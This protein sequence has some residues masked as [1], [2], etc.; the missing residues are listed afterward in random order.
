M[1]SS[2]R[3]Y[4]SVILDLSIG[5][6]LDYLLPDEM[7]AVI[8]RGMRVEVPIR[9]K[10]HTGYVLEVK[11]TCSYPSVKAVSRL[12]SEEEAVP[13]ELFELALWIAK[14]YCAPLSKVMKAILPAPVRKGGRHKQQLFV[15]RKKSREEIADI[16]RDLRN[17]FPAQAAVLDAM[18]L[19]K[20]GILLTELLEQ[21]ESSRSSVDALVKKGY[22]SVDIVRIDRSPL[23]GEEYFQ[24][25]P[26]TL[27]P[28]QRE[29]LEKIC[30]S[31]DK[32][33]FDVHLLHGVT[34]SGKTEVYLQAI[35]KVLK[36]DRGVIMLVPE[37]SLTAQ[38][39]E[40]LRGRFEGHIA[41]LHHRLSVG[42][43]FDEW[44]KI[45]EGKAQIVVGARSSIF[46]PV[47]DLGL[48]IVDEEHESS[49]KQSDEA[50][51]YAG[52]VKSR[53]SCFGKCNA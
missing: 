50:P 21:S 15:M 36:Q 44:H 22:L 41:I 30:L 43:R 6:A 17:K 52:Q 3:N 42:E 10:L 25:K 28:E 35:E 53:S 49:Y 38:T 24:T 31:I 4:V 7:R 39:I 8:R 12:L 32:Q 34:G 29:A 14:Y 5:K 46:S 1:T 18:L 11:E 19:V 47:K 9:G 45:R 48:I 27:S 40:R 33:Q 51:C 26:K 37:I 20:K 16:A 2:H 13:E 23:V